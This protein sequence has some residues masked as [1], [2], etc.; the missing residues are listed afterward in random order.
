MV[1]ILEE[2][3]KMIT[4]LSADS[5]E[6]DLIDSRDVLAFTALLSAV[7]LW[8]GSFAGMRVVVGQIPPGTVM[9]IR[10]ILAFLVITPFLGKI[11]TIEYRAGDLK[12]LIPMV[13]FQ[14]CFYFLFESNALRLTTSTQAGVIAA[15]VPLM[16]SVG[17]WL[18]FSEQLSVK[19]VI[20]LMVSVVGVVVLTLLQG[21]EQNALNP[22]MGNIFEGIAMVCAAANMLIV[23]KMS[24]NYNPFILTMFQVIAGC[25]FFSPGIIPIINGEIVFTYQ[26][27]MIFLY[28]GPCV[29]LGAFGLYNWGISRVD[30]AKASVFINLVP[31]AAVFFGWIMLG[32]TLSG[33]QWMAASGVIG[34]VWLTQK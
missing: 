27:L 7:L 9:F 34:G 6:N 20:G 19:T 31:V 33:F 23:K 21:E 17:A 24:E 14:P 26:Q 18:F 4:K 1:N 16:V 8:G 29:T 12:L 13:L 22:V 2:V 32:E 11:K 28:L 5:G 25:F 3:F 30:A 15:S 10:M